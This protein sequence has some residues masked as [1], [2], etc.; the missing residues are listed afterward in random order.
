MKHQKRTGFTLIELLVVIAI[1]TV[2]ISLLLPAVQQ[3]REAGRR[4]QCRNNL[5][6]LGIALHSY[7]D[8]HRT[9]PT[10]ASDSLYGY[11]PQALLLP[12]FEAKNLHD[13]IDFDEPLFG[14]LPWAPILNPSM[15]EAASTELAVLK[16]PSDSGNPIDVDDNGDIFAGTNYLLNGGSGDTLEYCSSE[17][18]GLFWRGCDLSFKDLRDGTT[19]TVFVAE[20]LFGRRGDDTSVLTDSQREMKRVSGGSPCST[21]A[22]DLVVLP[23]TRYEGRRAGGWIR[24]TGYNILVNAYYSPN[25]NEPDVAH[26]GE[27]ISGPRSSHTGGVNTLFCDGSVHF[28]GDGVNNDLLRKLFNRNDGEYVG[29]IE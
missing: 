16:C 9:F 15:R 1:I 20:G 19:Q 8:V 14:G 23:A 26:H 27:I 6:Q 12:Y 25:S 7:H 18:N 22:S 10:M 11:S 21:N 3:A 28:I 13:I 5:K 4:T 29:G 24:A 2:L 17:N